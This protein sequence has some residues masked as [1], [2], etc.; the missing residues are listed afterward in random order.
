MKTIGVPS[1]HWLYTRS[2]F[3]DA[4]YAAFRGMSFRGE[5]ELKRF[6]SDK[7][8]ALREVGRKPQSF[9]KD[10]TK[11]IE[12]ARAKAPTCPMGIRMAKSA[13]SKELLW[14]EM[15]LVCIAI[16]FQAS[17]MHDI[18]GYPCH[19]SEIWLRGL[20]ATVCFVTKEAQEAKD[21]LVQEGLK[22][23]QAAEIAE[24]MQQKPGQL[25][26]CLVRS[27][28]PGEK[29]L[30]EPDVVRIS[31]DEAGE[32]IIRVEDEAGDVKQGG[33]MVQSNAVKVARQDNAA[34]SR[35]GRKKP[36]KTATWVQRERKRQRLL[37]DGK[38]HFLSEAGVKIAMTK[39][40][41]SCQTQATVK[42]NAEAIKDLRQCS[43]EFVMR[44]IWVWE[45]LAELKKDRKVSP[46][47]IDKAISMHL[48]ASGFDKAER[49]AIASTTF[50]D[51]CFSSYGL[52]CIV[53]R[54]AVDPLRTT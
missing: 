16:G 39:A 40:I 12:F 35:E 8:S 3:R 17:A 51:Q 32:E 10:H 46:K 23:S 41:E 36:P 44:V 48:R 6:V 45:E 11:A 42:C 43:E 18:C 53:Q 13:D 52:K 50:L 15:G 9:S 37:E 27:R 14:G 22:T 25:Y 24:A 54:S 21:R 30:K 1:L 26:A 33:V 29:D 2:P 49:E 19:E 7:D 31:E 38:E 20:G 28:Q 47:S 5:A 4:D 34:T